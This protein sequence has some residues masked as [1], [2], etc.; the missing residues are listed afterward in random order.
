MT[1]EKYTS[2]D[3]SVVRSV[4][5]WDYTPLRGSLSRSMVRWDHL[6]LGPDH[7][8][9]ITRLGHRETYA[10]YYF[11]DMR[12]AILRPTLFDR[13]LRIVFWIVAAAV[14]A[15]ASIV[16]PEFLILFVPA[17]IVY[18][19]IEFSRSRARLT[20]CTQ[21]G[22]YELRIRTMSRAR[23]VLAILSSRIGQCQGS[24]DP[25][26]LRDQLGAMTPPQPLNAGA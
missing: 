24:L 5:R 7:L 2:L 13:N 16:P 25:A 22:I 8:L 20:L 4:E 10:R 12:Y 3:G 23:A 11:A 18:A 9:A 21:T 1:A 26:V 14:A 19:M 17:M 15:V 6:M